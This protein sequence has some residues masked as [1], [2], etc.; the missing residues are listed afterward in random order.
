M[1]DTTAIGPLWLRPL[2]LGLL[3]AASALLTASFTCV[4][5]FAAFA[6]IGALSLT[7][8][9]A[10]GFVAAVWLGNQAV[11]FGLLNYPW[12]A[13]SV[14][15]GLAIGAAAVLAT[16]AAHAMLA[17]ARALAS[18]LRALAAF[19]LAF[20]VY[21][22]ALYAAALSLL[23]G[24]GAFAPRIVGQVLLINAI[25]VVGLYGLDQAVRAAGAFAS[26]RRPGMSPARLA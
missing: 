1:R 26:R 8:W 4:T 22:L 7:R 20:G 18:P 6:V 23:G 12:T 5:P 21:Q 13:G 17:R 15:W 3:V 2:W 16:V 19:A 9:K 25:A 14:G 24:T 11:G 10:A